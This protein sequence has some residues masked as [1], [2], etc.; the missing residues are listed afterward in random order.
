MV[1]G[2]AGKAGRSQGIFVKAGDRTVV[3]VGVDV[4]ATLGWRRVGEPHESL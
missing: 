3:E 4:G 1:Q 2:K